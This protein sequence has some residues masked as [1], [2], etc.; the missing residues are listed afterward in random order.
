VLVEGVDRNHF[1]MDML[2][3]LVFGVRGDQLAEGRVMKFGLGFLVELGASM[4]D[5]L[6]GFFI[7]SVLPKLLRI[8]LFSELVSCS[9]R[10]L[11]ALIS[12]Q[13]KERVKR[14]SM[15]IPIQITD[16]HK[17]LDSNYILLLTSNSIE[18]DA[19][20]RIL[21]NRCD[22]DIGRS[23]RGCKIGFSPDDWRSM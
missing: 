7:F 2:D 23:T 12:M 21:H 17:E 3:L 5:V 18:R 6:Q 19:V 16:H 11:L 9:L 1:Q 13:A 8:S 22:A 10:S 4:S 20:N 15:S 14:R